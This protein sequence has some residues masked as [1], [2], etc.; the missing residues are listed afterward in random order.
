M[1]QWSVLFISATA[2]KYV[3]IYAFWSQNGDVAYLKSGQILSMNQQC[4]SF[5]F[6]T[7]NSRD[8]VYVYQNNKLLFNLTNYAQD[9]WHHKQTSI[10]M[11]DNSYTLV[12]KVIRE[13]RR[14]TYFGAIVI[15]DILIENQECDCKYRRNK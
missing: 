1:C 3:Y 15:D 11:S 2:G 14:N 6:F 13:N 10:G 5:W 9:K 7:T 4:L 12:F 8:S